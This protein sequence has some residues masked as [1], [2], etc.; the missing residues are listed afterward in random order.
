MTF[1][2]LDGI[3][4][5]DGEFVPWR[6]AKVHVLTHSLHYGM[7]IFEGIRAY[8]TSRGAA[9]FRLQD[10]IKRLFRSAHILRIP[11]PYEQQTLINACVDSVRNNTLSSAYIRPICFYGAEGMGLRADNIKTHVAIAA[12]EW[13]SYLGDDSL[14]KG[15]RI[16]TSSFTCKNACSTFC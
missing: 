1:D 4:W 5:M 7:G 13:G 11:M 16:K 2:D 6:E 8:K 9:I 15:I 10:H 14:E 12:W 3:I